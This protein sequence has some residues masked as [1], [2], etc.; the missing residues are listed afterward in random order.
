MELS[1]ADIQ[2]LYKSGASI[3]DLQYQI[4]LDEAIISQACVTDDLSI[5]ALAKG[6]VGALTEN[7][8]K[9]PYKL[10]FNGG[11][12]SFCLYNGVQVLRAVD[13]MIKQREQSAEGRKRLVLVHGNRFILHLILNIIKTVEG[14]DT[15]YL[16]LRD[17][18]KMVEELF[19]VQWNNVF[20][21]MEA[22][23][24]DSYPSYLFRN[25]G[26]LKSLVEKL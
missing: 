13:A 6:N 24:P 12:N 14:F 22:V 26:R 9:T 10:L 16:E 20:D 17:I 19:D 11:T 7:I 5:V 15:Q 1:F 21:A 18:E 23:F 3:D 8:E 25:V 2:Y 4:T